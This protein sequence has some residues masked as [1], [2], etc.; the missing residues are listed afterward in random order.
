MSEVG[1]KRPFEESYSLHPVFEDWVIENDSVDIHDDDDFISEIEE[2][3]K[4]FSNVNEEYSKYVVRDKCIGTLKL[5]FEDHLKQLQSFQ[6]QC[7][8][9]GLE[10]DAIVEFIEELVNYEFKMIR[11]I[12]SNVKNLVDRTSK[13]LNKE[14]LKFFTNRKREYTK[15]EKQEFRKY[16][17]A[18]FVKY[19][20]GDKTLTVDF[21]IDVD[22]DSYSVSTNAMIQFP[23]PK[24]AKEKRRIKEYQRLSAI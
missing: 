11:D 7:S 1:D 15:D 3:F 12:K 13:T 9:D 14:S 17:D 10:G 2:M 24:E 23:D 22:F 19:K 8:R 6:N 5:Q 20:S 4:D 21:K 18:M 16:L